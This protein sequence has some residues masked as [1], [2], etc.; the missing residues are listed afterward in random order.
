[1]YLTHCCARLSQGCLAQPVL[2]QS[3]C[4]SLEKSENSK[5]FIYKFCSNQFLINVVWL[6]GWFGM[7]GNWISLLD[8][9]QII[10]RELQGSPEKGFSTWEHSLKNK[11]IRILFPSGAAV[12]SVCSAVWRGEWKHLQNNSTIFCPGEVP[13]P[14]CIRSDY[15]AVYTRGRLSVLN[16]S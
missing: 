3:T 14:V 11:S 1:M 16:V 10:V 13:V 2:F 5:R 15:C 6:R 7:V 9:S 12:E 4:I 8:E